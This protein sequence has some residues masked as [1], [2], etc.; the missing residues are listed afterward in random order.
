MAKM[1]SCLLWFICLLF[2]TGLVNGQT[3]VPAGTLSTQ[4]WEKVNSPYFIQ[5][6]LFVP[7]D[8][9][10]TIEAGV[11]VIFE[12]F[13]ALEVKGQ[14]NANGTLADSI[15]FTSN[16]TVFF[17]EYDSLRGGWR[18]IRI[19]NSSDSSSLSYC[20]IE[21]GKATDTVLG[22]TQGYTHGG[23]ILVTDTRYIRIE[24]SKIENCLSREKGSAV[25]LH[26]VGIVEVRGCNVTRT[27]VSNDAPTY[28]E[29]IHYTESPTYPIE[30]LIQDN[31]IAN[32]QASGISIS[33]QNITVRGNLISGNENAFFCTG[34]E[35]LLEAN[36]IVYNGAGISAINSTVLMFN[37]VI[38]NNE[39]S[40]YWSLSGN[41]SKL[42]NNLFCN[43][44]NH[45]F[46]SGVIIQ[47]S[48]DT[49]INNIF[50]NNRHV[51][52]SFYRG[53]VDVS[54][55][56]RVVIRNCVFWNNIATDSVHLY[57]EDSTSFL[58]VAYCILDNDTLGIQSDGHPDSLV[59]GPI[60]SED[61]EFVN[62]SAGPGISFDGTLADW[63][64]EQFSFAIDHGDPDTSG[65]G[66]PLHD[67]AGNPR[68]YGG[69]IFRIDIGAYEYQGDYQELIADIRVSD[70]LICPG[71]TIAFADSSNGKYPI[72]SSLLHFGTGDSSWVTNTF[73]VYEHP[74]SYLVQLMVTDSIGNVDTSSLY[75]QVQTPPVAG[76][77]TIDTTLCNPGN[78]TFVNTSLNATGYQWDFG[79]GDS[80]ILEGPSTYYGLP[81]SYDIELIVF[82]SIG[83]SDTVIGLDYIR[84]IP[85]S[86]SIDVVDTA[87]MS[88]SFC[89]DSIGVE[90]W[91]W[92]FGDGSTSI[93]RC[94]N[95][96]F[97]GQ[98]E[99]SVELIAENQIGCK[100]TVSIDVVVSNIPPSEDAFLI[101]PNPAQDDFSITVNS[102]STENISVL[103]FDSNGR[104]VKEELFTSL[105]EGVSTFKIDVSMI[106]PGTYF[107]QVVS[108]G[109]VLYPLYETAVDKNYPDLRPK[110]FKL[111]LNR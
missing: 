89:L 48:N 39:S 32:N 77:Y 85:V 73:K 74:G 57:L 103:I 47:G 21:Y 97:P 107:V 65:L 54:G 28:R 44:E 40:G 104:K 86:A 38:S 108:G 7:Q 82:D 16:D 17:H 90:S 60:Y 34:S 22:F 8:S 79:N 105:K 92:D 64:L 4:T 51:S 111:L 84:Y 62:P 98:G 30:C 55:N 53:V 11:E 10:L 2:S 5:G 75:I 45:A 99:Y 52:T 66:L 12:G 59:V 71:D 41:R 88:Y 70:T 95:H 9:S 81:G 46:G 110:A 72:I 42:V 58:D 43:N 27:K 23:G 93:E 35:V 106:S 1:R 102:T 56:S 91:S 29:A 68:I 18:G 31:I 26:G 63:S 24:N 14:L 15:R 33:G 100:D 87:G 25:Y 80:S 61:P 13:Y 78:P 36:Q 19:R 69:L 3:V 96:Q 94:P 76:F 49:L 83:C 50:C 37:N 109:K 6:N 20:M 101:Y 67:I